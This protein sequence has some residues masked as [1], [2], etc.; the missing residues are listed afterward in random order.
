VQELREARELLLVARL[1]GRRDLGEALLD[2]MSIGLVAALVARDGEDA[3]ARGQLAVALG[4]EQGGHQLAPG[5]VAGA[6][7]ENEIEGHAK[8]GTTS[9]A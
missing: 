2:E 6:A 3:S 8:Q 9:T 4:L 1:L 5:K 7:E